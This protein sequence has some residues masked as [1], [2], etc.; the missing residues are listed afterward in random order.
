MVQDKW[1]AETK[2]MDA[3]LHTQ[4][5]KGQS[6]FPLEKFLQQH[7]NYYVS[8]QSCTA[9]VRY[10]LPNYHTMFGY[11][12]DALE[13][14]NP[15]L[16]AAMA[17]IEEDNGISVKRND[18]ELAVAY[19]LPKDPVLKRKS[20]ENNKRL[21]AHISDTNATY[22]DSKNGIGTSGVHLRWHANPEYKKF[23]QDHKKEICQ[24]RKE[25]E[26]KGK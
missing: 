18:F 23:I 19:I 17:N 12:L 25:H 9:H 26:V 3:L 10:Q 4:K 7:R 8:M 22:F 21:Q 20:N 15:P 1:D 11:L 5:W 13:S 2:K 24:W 6:N 16:L 14:Q